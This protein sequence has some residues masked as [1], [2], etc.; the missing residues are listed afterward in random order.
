MSMGAGSPHD[1]F[2]S[3]VLNSYRWFFGSVYFQYF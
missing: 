1:I 3:V 2:G